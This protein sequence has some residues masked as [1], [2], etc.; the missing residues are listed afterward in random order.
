ML[1]CKQFTLLLFMER[2]M[3]FIRFS[4]T[5]RFYKIW[6]DI[7]F[8]TIIIIYIYLQRVRVVYYQKIVTQSHTTKNK[9]Y[10]YFEFLI[11]I[12]INDLSASVREHSLYIQV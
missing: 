8:D 4:K 11:V 2:K 12:D 5:N 10:L 3:M 7:D 9:S 6:S 1:T